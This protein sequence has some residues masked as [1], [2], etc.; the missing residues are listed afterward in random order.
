LLGQLLMFAARAFPVGKQMESC[1]QTTIDTLEKKAKQTQNSPPQPNPEQIKANT[2][3]QIAQGK[4]QGDMQAEQ[5]RGQIEMAKLA[6]VREN[7]QQK[8]QLDAWVAQMEQRAQ[9]AQAAQE[10]QLEAQRNAMDA[11]N[12]ML[13]ERM[14]AAMDQQTEGIKQSMALF[15]AQ[16]NN[17]AKVEVAE[18]SAQSTLN[19]AQASA[20]QAVTNGAN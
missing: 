20:A 6:Q 19:A 1:L 11:H 15:I 16:L 7:D 18:I 4:Q 13:I 9:A 10:Q 8:A 17:A 3:L 14:R 12:E 2:Q 5:M